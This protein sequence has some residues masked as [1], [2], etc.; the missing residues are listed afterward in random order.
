V[1]VDFRIRDFCHPFDIYRLKRRFERRQWMPHAAIEADQRRRLSL[2][3]EHAVSKVPYYRRLS[4]NLDL[5]PADIQGTQ[6]M[7]RL[8]ILSRRVLSNSSQDLI[9]DDA[10]RYGPIPYTTSGTTGTPIRFY[11]DKS[12][13]V[14]EFVY[15]WRHWGWAGYRLGDRFAELGTHFFLKRNSV[16]HRIGVWQPHLRRLMLNSS[17]LSD[18]RVVEMT[19]AIRRH[20]PKF[21]K[22][23]ASALYFFALLLQEAGIKDIRFKAL[24]STGEV[25]TPAFRSRISEVLHGPVLDSYG[26]M[27]RTVA[28][29]ECPDG[30]YHLNLDYGFSEFVDPRPSDDGLSIRARLV[31]TSLYNMAMPLIRYDTGDDIELFAKPKRCPCGRSFPIIK[32]IH[33]RSEDTIVTPD[34]SFITAMFIIPE[35][36][37]GARFIQFIQESRSTLAVQVVPGPAWTQTEHHRLTDMVR[38]MAG[39]E[40]GLRVDMVEDND[41]VRDPSGKLRTVISRVAAAD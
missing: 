14:L 13:N 20:R 34:G 39:K 32:A 23:T 15:Y 5:T 31:G 18:S 7:A 35:L 11:L 41:L 25:L 16:S 6:G 12:S 9:A 1:A 33:G 27:E 28:I 10:Q 37:R 22:G 8:P 4:K 36:F 19:T 40:M 24:F 29:S 2:V 26:H 17:R 21:L 3:L 38:G 30:G